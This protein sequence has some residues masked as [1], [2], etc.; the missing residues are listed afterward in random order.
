MTYV[1][2]IEAGQRLGGIH[3]EYLSGGPFNYSY[4]EMGSM[5]FPST[6]RD[7]ATNET[8]NITDHQ[9][10]FQLAEEINGHSKNLSIAAKASLGSPVKISNSST[11]ELAA[12]VGEFM[13]GSELNVEMTK[14]MFKAHREWLGGDVWSESAFMVNYLHGSLNDTDVNGGGVGSFWDSLYEGMYFQAASWKTIHGGLNRPPLSFHPLFD[15]VT[16]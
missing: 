8:M 5:R 12:A 9:M 11:K 1:S 14:N 7:S 15:G 6:Y 4:Q 16:N 13:L 10:V 3:T 2:I